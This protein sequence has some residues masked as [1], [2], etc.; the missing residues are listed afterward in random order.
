MHAG[1]KKGAGIK[2]GDLEF[3]LISQSHEDHDGGLAEL[4]TLTDCNVKAHTVYDLLIRQYPE[5]APKG[6]KQQFPAKCWHCVMPSSFFKENCQGYHRVLQ[7]LD[8]ECIGD[9][10]QE[11]GPGKASIT[12]TRKLESTEITM[13]FSCF[14]SFVIS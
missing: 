4:V 5:M 6:Y 11:I 2:P 3:V 8:V 12:K 9:G 10:T 7:N 14:S 13:A 1:S